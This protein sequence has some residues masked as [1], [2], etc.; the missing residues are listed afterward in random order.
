MHRLPHRTDLLHLLR[1]KEPLG[2]RRKCTQ[3]LNP[4]CVAAG[5]DDH[6][7]LRARPQKEHGAGVERRPGGRGHARGDALEDGLERAAGGVT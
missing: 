7:T 3:P 2:Q 5:G 1:R 4:V 6:H